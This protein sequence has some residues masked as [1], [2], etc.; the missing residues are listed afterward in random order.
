[1]AL[2][3][4]IAHLRKTAG[5]TRPELARRI[6]L[7]NAQVIYALETRDSARSDYA[8]ALAAALGVPLE[9]LLTQDLTQYTPAPPPDDPEANQE[10]APYQVDV[11]PAGAGP[12]AVPVLSSKQAGALQGTAIAEAGADVEYLSG[13]LS[14]LVFAL[15]I[16][17]LS[18]MPEFRPGDR[19]IVEPALPPVP[20]D[21]VIA[22]NANRQAVF[23]K[24]KQRGTASGGDDIF[25]LVPLNDEFASLRSDVEPLGIIGVMIEHRKKYRRSR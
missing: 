3:K 21:F 10:R 11:K 23:R 8:P 1:M 18:M 19:V 24:Y 16:E 13:K 9:A 17:D 5:M 25:E 12:R 4:N 20:G 22:A 14:K 15:E 7:D 2:G 6:G